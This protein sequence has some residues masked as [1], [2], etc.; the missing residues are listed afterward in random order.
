M[1]E[2]KK[3]RLT[4]YQLVLGYR[5]ERNPSARSRGRRCSNIEISK[6]RNTLRT[7]AI[8]NI[9]LQFAQA[10]SLRP[11]LTPSPDSRW[12]GLE[13]GQ[14]ISSPGTPIL[15]LMIIGELCKSSNGLSVAIYYIP[16]NMTTAV[17][18]E[19]EFTWL[20]P[21]TSAYSLEIEIV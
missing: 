6:L 17:P 1:E 14:E 3:R 21:P 4:A 10:L 7:I 2:P 15:Y 19:V 5:Y 18:S 9:H 20:K 13:H 11:V 16:F 12:D 8:Y